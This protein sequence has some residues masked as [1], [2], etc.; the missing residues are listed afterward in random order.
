M[1]KPWIT[2]LLAGLAVV[3]VASL[4]TDAGA[5]VRALTEKQALNRARLCTPASGN[6]VKWATNSSTS[7]A[8]AA[9]LAEDTVYWLTCTTAS[10]VAWGTAAPTASDANFRLPVALFPFVTSRLQITVPVNAPPDPSIRMPLPA[11]EGPMSG[12]IVASIVGRTEGK[13]EGRPQIV[14]FGLSTAKP[15]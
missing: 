14:R 9:E 3:A 13:L 10:F 11:G 15:P 12:G 5:K 7:A 4:R 8:P 2:I 1:R 6:A